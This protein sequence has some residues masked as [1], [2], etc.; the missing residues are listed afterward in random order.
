MSMVLDS[1]HVVS[2]LAFYSEDSSS[3]PTEVNNFSVKLLLKI[4]KVSLAHL[5]IFILY[6]VAFFK[7]AKP[8]V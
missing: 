6:A 7:P 1:A 5:K 3:N 8:A 4:T 2:L